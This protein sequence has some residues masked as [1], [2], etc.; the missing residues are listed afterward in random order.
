M[1]VGQQKEKKLKSRQKTKSGPRSQSKS[2][3][4][5]RGE[6]AGTEKRRRK[7]RH[8]PS[9][10]EG[11]KAGAS[12]QKEQQH[13]ERRNLG[14][15]DN[16]TGLAETRKEKVKTAEKRAWTRTFKAGKIH[17]QNGLPCQHAGEP[18]LLHP[19]RP[20]KETRSGETK[21]PRGANEILGFEVG[22]TRRALGKKEKRGRRMRIHPGEFQ[23]KTKMPENEPEQHGGE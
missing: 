14:K 7:K 10:R 15:G 4:G 12:S 5:K 11:N 6:R 8:D 21:N 23:K 9:P 3:T 17:E 20:E 22:E 18:G 19:K 16:R 2:P 13:A 1:R